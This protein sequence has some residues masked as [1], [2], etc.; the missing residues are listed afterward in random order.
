MLAGLAILGDTGLELTS[1][2]GDDEDGAVGLGST[3]NHVLDEV[4]VSGS[5]NDLSNVASIVN[6]L[7]NVEESVQD[8]R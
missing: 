3:G 6:R 5:V 8:V 7:L 4:T 2:G 1:A